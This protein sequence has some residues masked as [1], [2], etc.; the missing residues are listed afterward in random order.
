MQSSVKFWKLI[1][2]ASYG[3]QNPLHSRWPL[4][5]RKRGW[6]PHL[7]LFRKTCFK[8]SWLIEYWPR[9]QTYRWSGDTNRKQI[10]H[11]CEQQGQSP[12]R[13]SVLSSTLCPSSQ[14]S[15]SALFQILINHFTKVGLTW[16]STSQNA[17]DQHL[18]LSQGLIHTLQGLTYVKC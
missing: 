6:S 9:L 10:V 4:P 8:N 14:A 5:N 12:P 11:H 16:A 13:R 17:S 15:I 7:L 2:G 18:M 1:W 3:V